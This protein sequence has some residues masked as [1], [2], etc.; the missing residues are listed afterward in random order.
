M[1]KFPTGVTESVAYTACSTGNGTDQIRFESTGAP[2]DNTDVQGVVRLER[3]DADHTRVT[4]SQMLAPDTPVPRLLQS[5]IKSYVQGEA[6]KAARD[7]LANVQTK[8]RIVQA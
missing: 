5:L 1:A 4:V 8:L 2:D 6:T 7:Y 3:V